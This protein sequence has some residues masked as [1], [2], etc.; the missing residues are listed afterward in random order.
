MHE[1]WFKVLPDDVVND[2][3]DVEKSL[4]VEFKGIRML[5]FCPV[6]LI[7]YHDMLF[8][9]SLE[10]FVESVT[11]SEHYVSIGFYVPGT[12][13]DLELVDYRV[14]VYPVCKYCASRYSPKEIGEIVEDEL[15]MFKNFKPFK[16]TDNRLENAEQLLKRGFPV[17]AE[18]EG[19]L[20]LIIP[21]SALDRIDPEDVFSGKLLKGRIPSKVYIYDNGEFFIAK[22]RD[23]KNE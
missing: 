23:G 11:K 22:K 7:A 5:M 2:V 12:L 9:D 1:S 19:K 20:V 8:V 17:V 14:L 3:K 4:G 10:K 15:G 13:K 21:K 18:M 16:M 6:C